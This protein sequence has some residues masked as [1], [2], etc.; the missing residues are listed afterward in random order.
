VTDVQR[1]R[2]ALG[3]VLAGLAGCGGGADVRSDAAA[4]IDAPSRD[5]PSIDGATD[6]A[7]TDATSEGAADAPSDDAATLD[8]R[9]R[10]LASYLAFLDTTP[11][12]A[13]SNGL[14]GADLADVCMLW[15]ALDPSSQAT[16]LTLT[17]RLEGSVLGRDG[18]TALSHVVRLYRVTGGQGATATDP[19]SCGG[20][21]FDRM[22]VSID[23]TLHDAL[24]AAHVHAGA[25]QA[26]GFDAA[27]IPAGGAWRDSHDLAGPHAPFDQSD[28][29]N[30]GAPRGQVQYFGD[31]SAAVANAA[32]GRTDLAA[33]VDPYALE[34]DQ[35]YDCVHASNPLCD[36]VTY[37][38]ACFPMASHSGVEIY[39]MNYGAIDLGWRPA[40]CP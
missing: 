4:A 34:I 11:D 22:I 1:T 23:A 31:P 33:L 5:A 29:T 14:R 2:V 18:T 7:T 36:Y 10:L 9:T 39:A 8:D 17:A 3:L 6:D 20:G 35:D 21:E 27:D 28:E 19:G 25:R 40:G 15:D 13:Q 26:Y 12:T 32:L 16:F 24:V 30:D 37:G 38:P